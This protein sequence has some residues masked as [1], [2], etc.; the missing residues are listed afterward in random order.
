MEELIAVVGLVALISLGVALV[1]RTWPRS[2]RLDG[3]LSRNVAPHEVDADVT[4]ANE[5]EE[6]D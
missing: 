1:V 3:I 2:S 6:R 4:T 5:P